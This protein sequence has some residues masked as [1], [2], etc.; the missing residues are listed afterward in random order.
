MAR[1]QRTEG[2][3]RR[4][5]RATTNGRTKGTD[6]VE[7]EDI[8]FTMDGLG[9]QYKE[10]DEFVWYVTECLTASRKNGKVVAKKTRPHSVVR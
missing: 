9:K 1:K 10:E 7:W 3:S 4:H 2:K 6:L 8:E 5:L